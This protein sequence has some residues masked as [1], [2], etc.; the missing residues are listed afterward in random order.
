MEPVYQ[1]IDYC[2]QV[3][4]LWRKLRSGQWDWLGID[5]SDNYI[6]GYPMRRGGVTDSLMVEQGHGDDAVL[7]RHTVRI[8]DDPRE[9]RPWRNS[10]LPDEASAIAEFDRFAGEMGT[11]PNYRLARVQRVEK[12]IIVQEWFGIA[13]HTEEWFPEEA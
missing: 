11:S 4:T 1:R 2:S 6:L 3:K 7:G 10:I 9:E 12:G 13:G 5:K 8:Y